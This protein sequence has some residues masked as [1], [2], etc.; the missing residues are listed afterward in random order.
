MRSSEKKSPA[1][2]RPH[3]EADWEDL[4]RWYGPLVRGQVHRLLRGSGVRPE[5]EQVDERV[6]EVYCRLLSGGAR[7]LRLLRAGTDVL[8]GRTGDQLGGST[9][10]A[11]WCGSS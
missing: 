10:T 11:V 6:Q 3:K 1:A 2:P 4:V 5:P 7:R 8:T 9:W